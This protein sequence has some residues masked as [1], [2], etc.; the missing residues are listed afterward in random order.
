[1]ETEKPKPAVLKISQDEFI[2]RVFALIDNKQVDIS[3]VD[4]LLEG[5]IKR[6]NLVSFYQYRRERHLSYEM[7]EKKLEGG[8]VMHFVYN[9]D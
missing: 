6:C 3:T 4:K 8:A 7:A 9:T 2:D 5:L 1:M